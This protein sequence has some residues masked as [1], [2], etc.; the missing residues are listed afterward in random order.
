[1]FEFSKIHLRY[2]QGT[3][4]CFPWLKIR[5]KA[6]INFPENDKLSDQIQNAASPSVL[7]KFL[8]PFLRN[9]FLELKE[10]FG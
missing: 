3:L 6:K 1:M 8:K 9:T 5:F 7:P 10:G 2:F 4:Y